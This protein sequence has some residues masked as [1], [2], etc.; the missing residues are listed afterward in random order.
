MAPGVTIPAAELRWQFT[1]AGGPGGQHVNTSSTRVQLTWDL[2][3]SDALDPTR[4]SRARRRLAGQ[5]VDGAITVTVAESRSQK[6]NRDLARQ[7][8]AVLVAD[9]IVPP[10]P[11]RRATRPTKASQARRVDAKVRRA[12]TKRLRGRVTGE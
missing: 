11:P 7:R 12:E 1:R 4:R 2:A 8:L 5:L 9:A 6:R 10:P 3:G